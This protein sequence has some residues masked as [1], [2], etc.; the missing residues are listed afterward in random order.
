MAKNKKWDN[1]HRQATKE[2]MEPDWTKKCIVCGNV[3][4]VPVTE[5]CGP[6]TWGEAATAGGNW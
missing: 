5:M 1:T 3:P 2:E 4:T 6:C